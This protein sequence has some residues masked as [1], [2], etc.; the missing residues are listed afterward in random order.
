MVCGLVKKFLGFSL[1]ISMSTRGDELSTL[2]VYIFCLTLISMAQLSTFLYFGAKL[3]SLY[4]FPSK[5]C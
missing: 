3:I 1:A 4:L 2:T 5:K